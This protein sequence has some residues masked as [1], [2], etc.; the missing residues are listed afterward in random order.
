V[1]GPGK[2]REDN[3]RLAIAALLTG[4]SIVAA[5]GAAGISESTLYRWLRQDQFQ[6][7][8]KTARQQAF[9]RAIRYLSNVS[10]Q[11][12]EVLAKIML[13]EKVP[14]NARV[15][16]ALGILERAYQNETMDVGALYEQLKSVLEKRSR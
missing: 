7:Q 6:Q 12:A 10:V 3:R 16:A 9:D 13:D 4:C 1:T 2:K 8:L 14:P 11:A 5:A 15:R